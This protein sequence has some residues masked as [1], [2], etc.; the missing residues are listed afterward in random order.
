VT[1]IEEAELGAQVPI[2]AGTDSNLAT[3]SLLLR[4]RLALPVWESY[5][6]AIGTGTEKS[7]SVTSVWNGLAYA[8]LPSGDA[9]ISKKFCIASWWAAGS[10]S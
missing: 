10:K 6:H 7:W 8:R 2:G 1:G 4:L 3:L 5:Y 9:A